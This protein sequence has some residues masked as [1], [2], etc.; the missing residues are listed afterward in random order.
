MNVSTESIW[1]IKPG[2]IQPFICENALALNTACS[3]VTR[4]KRVG[5]P[6]G[7]ALSILTKFRKGFSALFIPRPCI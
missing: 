2:T 7:V 1:A 4:L 3:L 5:L 6:D